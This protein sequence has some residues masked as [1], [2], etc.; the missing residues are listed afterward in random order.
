M[1]RQQRPGRTRKPARLNEP[2][3]LSLDLDCEGLDP[4][5]LECLAGGDY[6]T[7]GLDCYCVTDRVS[8]QMSELERLYLNTITW[9]M[10]PSTSSTVQDTSHLTMSTTEVTILRTSPGYNGGCT[11]VQCS[12]STILQDKT[13]PNTR[14]GTA[15]VSP[16]NIMETAPAATRQ[17]LVQTQNINTEKSIGNNS[18]NTSYKLLRIPTKT[19]Y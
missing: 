7:T 8:V 4:L 10:T 12:D 11:V 13:T 17:Q 18:N 14:I 6:S 5:P 9:K 19:E 3:Q 16:A 15:I 2:S 1:D